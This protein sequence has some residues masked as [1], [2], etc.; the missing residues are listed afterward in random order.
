MA[1]SPHESGQRAPRLTA[2]LRSAQTSW[3]VLM[4]NGMN[5]DFSC[6]ASTREHGEL[7]ERVRQM[8]GAAQTTPEKLSA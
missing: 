2:E 5:K 4:C 6:N 8:R 3:Q 1:R 7:Y